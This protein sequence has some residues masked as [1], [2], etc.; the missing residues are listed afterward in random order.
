MTDDP[1]V[2]GLGPYAAAALVFGYAVGLDLTRRDL[3]A[4]AK[5]VGSAKLPGDEGEWVILSG[6]GPTASV[7]GRG[8]TK[9]EAWTASAGLA[10]SEPEARGG[11][12]P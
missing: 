7:I 2:S 11:G 3:Q 1:E 5:T 9:E 8:P 12:R 6:L 10:K 4:E